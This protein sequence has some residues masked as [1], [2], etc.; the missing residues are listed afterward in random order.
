MK[1]KVS[2]YIFQNYSEQQREMDTPKK[3]IEEYL[4]IMFWFIS[5]AYFIICTQHNKSTDFD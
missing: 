5:L 4:D 3:L 2:G 1:V